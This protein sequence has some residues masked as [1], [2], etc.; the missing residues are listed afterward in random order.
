MKSK[1][2]DITLS[3][4]LN[5][6]LA[7]VGISILIM[8]GVR[9]WDLQKDTELERAEREL[10][11]IIMFAND[12]D[13]VNPEAS[14][15]VEFHQWHLVTTEM[16]NWRVCDGPFCICMCEDKLCEKR[17]V[18]KSTEKFILLRRDF[19]ENE[20]NE[21]RTIKQDKFF[22]ANLEFIGKD[23]YPFNAEEILESVLIRVPEKNDLAFGLPARQQ[24]TV[25][26]FFYF[27]PLEGLEWSWG[28]NLRDWRDLENT[29]ILGRTTNRNL[30]EEFN[31]HISEIEYPEDISEEERKEILEKKGEEF[32]ENKGIKKSEGVIV[33]QVR[34]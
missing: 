34:T 24:R 6:I 9:L 32:L 8:L 18:C 17:K 11:R 23:V 10:D 30:V 25:P 21:M 7:I 31:Q 29:G 4:V 15:I 22:E 13:E 5:I 28:Y 16:E 2:G 12:L 27:E 1:K 20:E 19:F 33:L 3:E 26:L 14:T